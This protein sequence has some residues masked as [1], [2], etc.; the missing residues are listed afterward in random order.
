M[1]RARLQAIQIRDTTGNEIVLNGKVTK[2]I[3]KNNPSSPEELWVGINEQANSKIVLQA[4]DSLVL[5]AREGLG[6]Q[7]NVLRFAFANPDAANN[8]V[9]IIETETNEPVC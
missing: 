7:G 3:I 8:A 2:V 5:D 9:I 6:Y 4:T 1:N